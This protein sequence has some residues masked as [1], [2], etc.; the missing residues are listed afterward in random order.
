MFATLYMTK[1][2]NSLYKEATVF[3]MKGNF[4][5]LEITLKIPLNVFS[6]GSM[7]GHSLWKKSKFISLKKFYYEIKPSNIEDN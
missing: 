3:V 1:I 7:F 5:N 4:F 2:E 6:F